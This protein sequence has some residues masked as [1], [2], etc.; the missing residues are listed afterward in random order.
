M[1]HSSST[2]TS[3]IDI[4]A[5]TT[6]EPLHV[7]SMLADQSESTPPIN[8]SQETSIAVE[9]GDSPHVLHQGV[10]PSDD[11]L[12]LFSIDKNSKDQNITDALK[13]LEI[14]LT[15]NE[16]ISFDHFKYSL[17]LACTEFSNIS[18]KEIESYLDIAECKEPMMQFYIGSLYLIGEVVSQDYSKAME[19]YLKAAEQGHAGTQYDVGIM[20]RKGQGV[21]QDYSKAMEWCLR[22]AEQ[23]LASAQFNIGVMYHN[24]QGVPQDYSKAMEWYLRA[25]EQ[26]HVGALCNIGGMYDE[27]QG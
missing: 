6:S 24:G 3:L 7:T 20:Y 5:T 2:S 14:R 8:N 4:P 10:C 17:S 12:H 25:V 26:G 15:N 16:N 9:G 1:D 22:A 21:Q 13:E 18:Q 23:G 11:E 27:G 19:W